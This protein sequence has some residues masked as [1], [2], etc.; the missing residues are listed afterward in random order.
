MFKTGLAPVILHIL[1]F[2]G[3]PIVRTVHQLYY[4]TLHVHQ[5]SH[6]IS[7]SNI[8][9]ITANSIGFI[10]PSEFSHTSIND[11]PEIDGKGKKPKPFPHLSSE[12]SY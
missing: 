8:D 1:Y 2:S 9:G 10:I 3:H 11:V 5:A 12:D 7:V 6:K 4:R